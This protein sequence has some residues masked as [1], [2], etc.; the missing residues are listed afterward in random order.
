VATRL[1][2]GENVPNRGNPGSSR[3]D[4]GAARC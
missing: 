4:L 2:A 1:G 3:G